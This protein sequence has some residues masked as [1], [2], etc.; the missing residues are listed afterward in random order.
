MLS[1]VKTRNPLDLAGKDLTTMMAEII[2]ELA[3]FL[4][5]LPDSGVAFPPDATTFINKNAAVTLQ[6][7]PEHGRPLRE[8][9]DIIVQ[10]AENDTNTAG[11]GALAFIPGSG[12]VSSAAADLISG[13]FNRY[14]SVSAASPAMVALEAEVLR[15]VASLMGLPETSGGF[16]T[17]GASMAIFSAVVCARN[18]RLPENF[19]DGV[20]YTTDQTH[21]CLSKE[22]RLAGFPARA[23]HFVPTDEHLR[24]NVEALRDMIAQDRKAGLIP[25]CVAANAG[26]TNVGTID[27][28]LEIATVAKEEQLWF[29]VDG[30]YG[31]F[32]QLT[33]RGKE[34][35]AGIEYAD[36]LVVDFHKSMFLPFG[37]GCLL[38]RDRTI[39]SRAHSGVEAF[40]LRDVPCPDPSDALLPEFRDMSPELTRPN[41]GLR[42]WLPLHLHGISPFRDALNEKLDLTEHAY[43]ELQKMPQISVLPDPDLSIV[44]FYCRTESGNTMDDDIATEELVKYANGTGRVHLSTTRVHERTVARIAILNVRTTAAIVD[45]TLRIIGTYLEE[46]VPAAQEALA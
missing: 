9:L 37:T 5:R 26:T 16:L 23:L 12:L 25:F 17:S 32:F 28:L 6:P 46:N 3:A 44:G 14:T 33:E 2:P 13:I 42:V 22:M 31:G 15:W 39:L 7:P 35:L 36:S 43:N 41:R 34:R 4:D 8:L 20:V 1:T 21:A 10:A 30:A 27:P 24:M 38:V 18:A 29:H 40:C 19:L 45:E 11:G